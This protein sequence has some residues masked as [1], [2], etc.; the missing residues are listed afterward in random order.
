[1]A[2][3][4]LGTKIA[5]LVLYNANVLTMN[6]R[7]PHAELV[8][9]RDGRIIHVGKNDELGQFRGRGKLI[10]CEGRTVIPGFNDAHIHVLSFSSHL[11]SVDCSPATVKSISDIQDKLRQEAQ[12]IPPGTWIKGSGYNE[13][14]LAER[15]HPTRRDLD[16]AAP[17]HPVKLAH[18]SM[19][20]CVLNSMALSLAGIS[21]ETPD[22]PG[23]LID[24]ELETG[25][26]SGLLFGMNSY[27]NEKVI[28]PLT[29]DET[30][31]GVHVANRKLL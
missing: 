23:G 15:R 11:L 8:A 31:R 26:P 7:Q 9:V 16:Q 13:F 10:D 25:E 2:E 6:R 18:R 3:C 27:I 29:E 22:P 19:H 24:R 12:R 21:V 20:A 28:P 14:Y 1:M 5:D 17:H 4:E 30:R